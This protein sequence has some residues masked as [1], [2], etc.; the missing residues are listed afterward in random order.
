MQAPVTAA[1]L[2]VVADKVMAK[3]DAIDG[4][5]DGLIDDPR[6]ATSTP[7]WTFPPAALGD[8][9]PELPDRRT[10]RSGPQGLRRSVSNGKPFFPEICR[11]AKR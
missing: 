11:A 10:G 3:C 2:A 5:K 4:L 1:K 9:W 8:R 7:R 6:S